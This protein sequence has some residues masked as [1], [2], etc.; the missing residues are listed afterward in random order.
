MLVPKITCSFFLLSFVLSAQEIQKNDNVILSGYNAHMSTAPSW[1]DD[2]FFDAVK[3]LNSNTFRYPGGSNSFYWNWRTGWTYSYK[4]MYSVL[5]KTDFKFQ[6]QEIVSPEQLAT[7]SKSERQKNPFWRQLYRYN[8]FNIRPETVETFSKVLKDNEAH[9]VFTLNLISSDIQNEIEMLKAFEKQGVDIKYIELGNEINSENLITKHLYPTPQVYADTCIKWS[10]EIWKFFPDAHIGFVGGNK[11]RRLKNWNEILIDGLENEF[12]DKKEQIHFILHYYPNLKNPKFDLTQQEGIQ[13]FLAYPKMDLKQRLKWW[14]WDVTKNY[15]TWITEFNL[16]EEKPWNI[17]NTWAH[18]LFVASMYSEFVE[19]INTTMYHF[20][21]IGSNNFAVFSSIY[22][23]KENKE[24]LKQTPTGLVSSLWN[25]FSKNATKISKVNINSETWEVNYSSRKSCN[26]P[27]NPKESQSI[28]FEPIK[29]F[30]SKTKN[31]NSLFA[32]NLSNEE[33]KLDINKL[34]YNT[35]SVQQYFS[36][37]ND[38]IINTS[39][40][41]E[42]TTVILNPY[43]ISLIRP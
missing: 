13:Q 42:S 33:Y 2:L 26:C 12:T 9:G 5:K 22:L 8:N 41:E 3:K 10:M 15:S 21:S 20:H 18:G 14:H 38:I 7:L 40:N 11:G 23:D 17:N 16:I 24:Y 4:E 25:Q 43:S 37:V 31:N 1:E 28:R 36:E 30:E 34:G 27:N 35:V 29:I 39:L 19:Q 32:I 6:G